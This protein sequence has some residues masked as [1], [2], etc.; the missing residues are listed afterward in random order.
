MVVGHKSPPKQEPPRQIYDSDPYN[1]KQRQPCSALAPFCQLELSS[2]HGDKL[3]CGRH[4]IGCGN[5]EEHTAYFIGALE[6]TINDM[7]QIGEARGWW[8]SCGFQQ[9]NL[10]RAPSRGATHIPSEFRVPAAKDTTFRRRHP[11]S[12]TWTHTQSLPSICVGLN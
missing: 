8:L 10:E 11:W 5:F 6:S 2:A 1:E 12:Q 9:S 7:C 3:S 4:V